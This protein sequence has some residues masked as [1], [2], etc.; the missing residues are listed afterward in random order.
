MRK[1]FIILAFFLLSFNVVSAE[2]VNLYLFSSDSCPHCRA[3]KK[4]LNSIS[5]KYPELEIYDFEISNRANAQALQT[6]AQSLGKDVRGVPFTIIGVFSFSGFGKSAEP[7]IEEQ[8]RECITNGCE[9]KVW[10]ILNLGEIFDEKGEEIEKE[11]PEEEKFSLPVVGDFGAKD[12]SLPLLAVVIG[13]L[14]GFNPCAMWVLLFLITML[15]GM[16]NKK[17]RWILG[18]A[19]IA[20]SAVVYFAFMSL[21]LNI[22]LFLGFILAIR[23]II[24]LVA[25]IGGAYSLKKGFEPPVCKVSSGKRQQKILDKIKNIVKKESFWL[26]L[27]G[28]I[29]LAFAVNLIELICSAGFP[30]VFTQVLAINNLSFIQYYGYILLYIFFFMLDDLV[31]FALAMKT[32]EVTGLTTKYT[33]ITRIVGGLI[34]IILGILLIFKPEWIMFG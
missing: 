16:E 24:G 8:I 22:I 3:E 34:M 27:I 31:V 32:L 13:F 23:I 14:D 19:F 7:L 25:L 33:K 17:R 26:A 5:D 2:E 21:W 1:I 15:I 10:N 12:I 28:I 20:A 6:V 4:F 11:I 30:A 18:I 9:D 29:L